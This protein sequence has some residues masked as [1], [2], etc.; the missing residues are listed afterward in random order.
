MSKYFF[1]P[2]PFPS[3][4]TLTDLSPWLLFSLLPAHWKDL[5]VFSCTDE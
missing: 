3:T 1:P 2:T 4:F 5:Q